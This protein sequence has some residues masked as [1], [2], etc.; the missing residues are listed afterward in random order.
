M[1]SAQNLIKSHRIVAARFAREKA[2]SM[3]RTLVLCAGI[4]DTAAGFT[5][6]PSWRIAS[7]PAARAVVMK[8]S[9][10]PDDVAALIPAAA[11][12]DPATV[13]LW[14]ALRKCYPDDSAAQAALSRNSNLLMPWS[15]SPTVIQRNWAVL[16][17]N[18]GKE[19]ALDVITKNPGV[20]ACDPER[21]AISSA[22]EIKGV[23]SFTAAL[24]SARTALAL[25]AAALIAVALLPTI[26]LVDAEA[27]GT[28][29]R[30]AIGTIGAT[31]F[32]AAV[33][34]AVAAQRK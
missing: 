31:A 9:L 27:A 20:L 22:E 29:L 17:A 3:M 18:L 15:N 6:A 1:K 12:N 5:S 19:D 4:F 26:G 21:L 33:L 14:T 23:A 25:A 32:F 13:P 11:A 24:A 10:L 2:K 16:Q 8:S 7:H 28:V 34:G 30:P